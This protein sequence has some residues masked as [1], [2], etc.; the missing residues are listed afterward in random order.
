MDRMLCFIC[1]LKYKGTSYSEGVTAYLERYIHI[2]RGKRGIRDK[3][4]VNL[5]HFTNIAK[6]YGRKNEHRS[7]VEP[8]RSSEVL[9]DPMWSSW[10]FATLKAFSQDI[11]KKCAI[12]TSVYFGKYK[13]QILI[14][15]FSIECR[16]TKTK[17]IT[18][19]MQWTNQSSKQ[20]RL[21]SAERGKRVLASHYWF[22]FYFSLFE[23]VA[24]VF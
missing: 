7:A 17:A 12:S 14:E 4:I 23:D 9:C 13:S 3:G 11:W 15:R 6:N 2:F 22:W 5:R 16:N 24:R 19:P 10:Y 21:S 18:W 20:M 8:T 1:L